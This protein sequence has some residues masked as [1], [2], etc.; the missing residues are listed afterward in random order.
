MI[1]LLIVPDKVQGFLHPRF[2]GRQFQAGE[3]FQHAGRDV[4]GARV[5][6][7]IVIGERHAAEDLHVVVAI[8]RAPTAVLIGEGS[9]LAACADIL[10]EAGVPIVAIATGDRR[11]VSWAGERNIPTLDSS[12]VAELFP[13]QFDY[14]FSIANLRVLPE[15]LLLRARCGAIN[16]H[17]GLLPRFAGLNV[18][19]WAIMEGQT[20]HGVT[21]HEMTV[22]IDAGRIL[23]Q[24]PLTIDPDETTYSL[25][26]KCL[27]AGIATF[28]TLV[29]ELC[30]S[31]N[32]PNVQFGQR[33]YYGLSKRPPL[34]G[35]LDFQRPALEIERLVRALSAGPYD[36]PLGKAKLWTGTHLLLVGE[37]R[38][39]D[40]VS[41]AAPGTVLEVAGDKVIVATSDGTIA[42][43]KF[44]A[45]NGGAAPRWADAG[46][47][48]TTTL[49]APGSDL[50]KEIEHL[51]SAT[52]RAQAFWRE[53]FE[54]AV[55]S[56]LPYPRQTG[57][58]GTIVSE[59]VP[60]SG[61]NGDGLTAAFAAWLSSL[62][63]AR[64]VSLGVDADVLGVSAGPAPW[65][66]QD[67]L[68][69]VDIAEDATPRRVLADIRAK[70]E[71]V[72]STGPVFADHLACIGDADT[73]ETA[74]AAL[75]IA[76]SAA[77]EAEDLRGRTL[78]LAL[79]RAGGAARFVACSGMFAPATLEAMSLSFAAFASE[80]LAS[81]D[82]AVGELPLTSSAE[83]AFQGPAFDI[84]LLR[85]EEAFAAQ[86]ARTP[87]RVAV[88]CNGDTVTFA[89]LDARSSFF[90]TRL[91]AAGARPGQF[92]GLC[93][94]RS[95]QLVVALLAIL[96]TGAAYLPLDPDFPARRVASILANSGAGV[97][98]TS[99]TTSRRFSF[100]AQKIVLVDGDAPTQPHSAAPEIEMPGPD[101][102]AYL[103]YTSGSTGE[104]KGVMVTHRNVINFFAGMDDRIPHA[105]GGRLLAVTSIAFDISVLELLWTLTR[106][107]TVV[108][109][110]IAASP[111][112]NFSLFYFASD[113]KEGEGGRYDLLLEGA[114]FADKAGFEAVWTPERHFHGF[115]GPYPNPAISGAALSTLTQ[116]IKIRAG[117]CVLPLHHPIRVA[118]DW[119]MIDNLSGGRAGL[120][121]ASG[122]QPHDFVI[123]PEAFAGR[124]ENVAAGVGILRKLWAG[125]RVAFPG[126]TGKP[127]EIGTLP[128]PVQKQIPLWITTAGN[129]ETY[130]AAAELG[131]NVLT[132]LLGQSLASVAD[133]IRHYRTAWT[134][135][136]NTGRGRV[137]L[138]LH[139]F[140]GDNDE[141]VRATVREPMKR[142]L[143][144]ALSLVR[145]ASWTFPTFVSRAAATGK[146]PAEMFDEQG[147]SPEEMDALLEHAFDRYFEESGL[148]GSMERC[149]AIVRR[150][151]EID[152]DEIACLIDFGVDDRQ[153]LARLPDLQ[154]LMQRVQSSGGSRRTA[155]TANDVIA[156]RITHLQ[157]TPSQARLLL[158]DAAGRSAL[159][160]LDVMMVGGEALPAPLAQELREHVGGRL[161]N[162]Y[163]PTETTIWS[164]VAEVSQVGDFV[165]LGQ[166]IANTQLS[167]RTPNDAECPPLIAGELTIGG[168]GV[169]AGYWRRPEQTQ[170]RFVADPAAGAKRRYRTGDMVRR[171]PD[172]TLEFLGRQ[173]NQVKLRGHRMELGEIE[174]ALL[175]QPGISEAAVVLIDHAGDPELAAFIVA[176]AG[177]QVEATALLHALGEELPEAMTPRQ[178]VVLNA[179]PLN[180]NGKIDRAALKLTAT[181]QQDAQPA[182]GSDSEALVASVW[183]EVLGL[184]NPGLHSNFFDLGGHSLLVIQV[185]RRLKEL[186]GREIPIV[187]MFAN[188]TIYKLAQCLSTG[189]ST[190]TAAQAGSERA[191][192]RKSRIKNAYSEVPVK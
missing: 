76:V 170:E 144:S 29:G 178:V 127:I 40:T 182:A 189:P 123:R 141:E 21:W 119:A 192:L 191:R 106:G 70:F 181:P 158:A 97:I 67:R 143:G 98:A 99:T 162:M 160:E 190:D 36:H 172:G 102:L 4:A 3:R 92:V 82:Q 72:R 27:Q 107:L 12:C 130:R 132:H 32:T 152:V 54:S 128:R 112:P 91:R 42:L 126:P 37:A 61:A 30:S 185:Q 47:S 89:E 122:W 171:W 101:D 8:E 39:G 177:Q 46:V 114:K 78:V 165:S 120:A 105:D 19:A 135:A 137:T 95:T 18:P 31:T 34:L 100:G 75:R 20:E 45:M 93:V 169:A 133:K 59:A 5:D 157:C 129:P 184:A 188:P 28:R 1:G 155:S 168:D 88:E 50:A 154:R 140:V 43:G 121:L 176:A 51:C 33:N 49:P 55:L 161:F 110:S 145:D 159:S 142:Y 58:A 111:A 187:D 138:M 186:A 69:N 166:P 115:G 64:R 90:A 131:C 164:T 71:Q 136:G 15:A 148:F 35:A 6:H 84:P 77:K 96:K 139:T 183:S 125:E 117:S 57:P 11:I 44:T 156:N 179:M 60:L 153:V 85:I 151:A 109:Q 62:T 9:L 87:E 80:F 63:G 116:N 41:H 24:S 23:A 10:L 79:N 38:I 2:A 113:D 66:A 147:L 48:P 73:R 83:G 163:G 180:T 52:A 17:D 7:R 175:R 68:L 124:K 16:F 53:Q 56:D 108:V 14:L 74:L 13:L 118:E 81:P 150:V 167:V 25:N 134:E 174:A 26:V 103:I 149:E 86:V 173:D 22:A 94:E 104:P 65:F 146:T